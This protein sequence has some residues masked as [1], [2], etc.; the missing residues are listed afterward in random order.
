MAPSLDAVNESQSVTF[1]MNVTDRQEF[2]MPGLFV[3][4]YKVVVILMSV[5]VTLQFHQSSKWVL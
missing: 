1:R 2:P 3:V 4:L 5:N